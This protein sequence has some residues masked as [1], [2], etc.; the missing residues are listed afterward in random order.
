MGNEL[1]A[2]L[3]ITAKQKDFQARIIEIYNASSAHSLH[4]LKVNGE[5]LKQELK[6]TAGPIIGKLVRFLFE[7]VEETPEA[8]NRENLLEVARKFLEENPNGDRSVDRES[9]EHGA[10]DAGAAGSA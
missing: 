6:L 7:V 10:A 2:H 3:P 8:N 4:D 5:D 9:P 1:K